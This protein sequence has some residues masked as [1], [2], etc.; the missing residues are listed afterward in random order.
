MGGNLDF[1]IG[2]K[3]IFISARHWSDLS[4]RTV[5]RRALS[6]RAAETAIHGHD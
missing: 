3:K 6:F 1:V 2:I 4:D 5:T